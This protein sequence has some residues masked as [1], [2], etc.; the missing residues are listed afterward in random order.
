MGGLTTGS[1]G[2][3]G[4]PTGLQTGTS[5]LQLGTGLEGN[6]SPGPPPTSDKLLA[7]NGAFLLAENGD[8]ILTG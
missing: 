6:I 1:T 2:L 7:E 3:S 8:Y 5:G 4:S